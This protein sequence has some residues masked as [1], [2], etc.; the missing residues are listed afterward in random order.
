MPTTIGS[1]DRRA[2]HLLAAVERELAQLEVRHGQQAEPQAQHRLTGLGEAAAVQ[3]LQKIRASKQPVRN[4]SA[5]IHWMANYNA[6]QSTAC[7]S[8]SSQQ[9]ANKLLSL[10]ACTAWSCLRG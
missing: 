1:S 9:G 2:C 8:S 5:Y 3:V 7:G 4:L 10:C 6:S